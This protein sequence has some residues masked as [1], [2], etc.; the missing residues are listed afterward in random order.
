MKKALLSIILIASSQLLQAT[1]WTVSF[2]TRPAQFTNLQTAIDSASA[3]DTV[4]INGYETGWNATYLRKPLVLMGEKFDEPSNQ[5]NNNITNP[6]PKTRIYNLVLGRV[7]SYTGASGS[8][9]YGLD[10][11]YLY[12]D[13]DFSGAQS[14]EKALDD[15]IVE[16]CKFQ[17][18]NFYT[19]S[20]ANWFSNIT[21][22]NSVFTNNISGLYNNAGQVQH[23]NTL[24]TNCVFSGA[25]LTGSATY[26]LNGQVLV[27]NCVFI[28]RT[29]SNCFSSI[30]G[31]VVSDNI[32]YR[33]EPGGC[34]DCTYNNNLTYNCLDNTLPPA[35]G[36]SVGS[37]NIE[38]V[39]PQWLNYPAQ[40]A[41]GWTQYHDYSS[42]AGSP[43]LGT[44]TNGTNIG[45]MGGNAP[46]A[47]IP[48]HPKNPEVIEVDIPVS[49]VPAGGTLQINLKAKTRD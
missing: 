24:F 45:L 13:P 27:R 18:T 28:N 32:F 4:L 41:V 25:Y 12:L 34:T 6:Y 30:K 23:S 46:V 33:S 40:G 49:S 7:N 35:S 42:S 11:D 48:V 3:G 37:G 9:I 1:V 14:G 43:V 36:N 10:I 5:S 16:R 47:N 44:G 38:Q 19:A 29:A 31:L 8:R 21:F 2:D 39:D 26:S 22:R 17:Y 15:V 20:G